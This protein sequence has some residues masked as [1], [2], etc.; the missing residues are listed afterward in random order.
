MWK[1]VFREDPALM[2]RKD[3]DFYSTR[4]V[5]ASLDLSVLFSSVFGSQEVWAAFLEGG[6]TA[7]TALADF[8]ARRLGERTTSFS[9]CGMYIIQWA[10]W[11]ATMSTV[12]KGGDRGR[13][14]NASSVVPFILE[15]TDIRCTSKNELHIGLRLFMHAKDETM[16]IDMDGE[17]LDLHLRN[18]TGNYLSEL[19]ATKE[20]TKEMM[21]HVAT[22]V[23]QDRLR[24]Q[25]KIEKA[26]AFVANGAIL[27]RKSGA[28]HA[29]MASPPAVPFQ[30]PPDSKMNGTLKV[31]MGRLRSFLWAEK[32][33]I[34]LTT[35]DD[36]SSSICLNGLLVPEGISLIVGGGYHGKSTLLRTIACGVYNKIP[37]DGREFSVTVTDAM[38]VRAE[39]GR[40]VNNCNISAFIS[41]LPTL[42]GMSEV[43][44]T[45]RF[46]TNEASGS[47]SQAANVVEAIEMGCSALLVDEDV[48]AANFMARDGRMRS[49]VMDESITPL[50]YR[51]NGLYASRGIS[52]I[53]VVGG[54]GDWLD[55]PDAVILMD[56]YTCRDATEK[57]R[58]VSRQFS[59][60]HVQYGGRGV[61]HRL[62]WEKTGTPIQRR[63][64][65]RFLKTIHHDQTGVALIEGSHAILLYHSQE[66]SLEH[67]YHDDNDEDRLVD[68]SKCE[69][70]MGKKYQLYGCGLCLVWLL[71]ES[72]RHPEIGLKTLLENMDTCMD[73]TDF[74]SVVLGDDTRSASLRHDT[75]LATIGHAY[76]PRRFEVGQAL[77]RLRGIQLE[78]TPVDDED[79][80]EKA[81][82]AE[83]EE[84]KKKE[85]LDLWN[86]RRKK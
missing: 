53:V 65:D 34:S 64:T 49:L 24:G 54:V 47:T 25:L 20:F 85:L 3:A 36:A 74:A 58:S 5:S 78:N 63:P 40:Y 86:A 32:P 35:Y 50:L 72:G 13:Q 55:V 43:V 57:A 17:D 16:K 71:E 75:L 56:K 2:L 19:F 67:H 73:E 51:V 52:S 15:R 10:T 29:P 33:E 42:P 22:A 41:N 48:S 30:A 81:R 26:V 9:E 66:C 79:E 45:T 62:S 6:K 21:S 18:A 83:E 27:P 68:M 4:I 44:D 37:G 76:R 82:L 77:T 23:L 1:V 60:G 39:D 31:S 80:E 69:Q 61:V 38:T 14:T 8:V 11:S 7:R 12:K 70:L 59:H 46:S 84:R 28:S